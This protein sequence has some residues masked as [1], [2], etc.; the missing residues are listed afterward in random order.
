[1]KINIKSAVSASKYYDEMVGDYYGALLSTESGQV[2]VLASANSDHV[3][4]FW[5][6]DGDL[7]IYLYEMEEKWGQ[8]IQRM[9]GESMLYVTIDSLIDDESTCLIDF[10]VK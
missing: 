7:R 9:F 1:M 5:S 10:T 2:V 6:D 3:A 8:L 4:A